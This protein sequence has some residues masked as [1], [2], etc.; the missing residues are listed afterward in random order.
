MTR[1]VAVLATAVALVAAG[2][3]AL[4]GAHDAA[5][6]VALAGAVACG[7]GLHVD[8]PWGGRLT[9]GH[10]LIIAILARAEPG[11]SLLIVAAG[12]VLSLPMWLDR[13]EGPRLTQLGGAAAAAVA[14]AAGVAA[15]LVLDAFLAESVR[16]DRRSLALAAGV[17]V[18]FLGV[19]HVLRGLVARTTGE[20]P[21]LRQAWPLYVTL[22]CVGALVD[23]A[24]QRSVALALVATLPLLVTRFSFQRYTSARRTYEQTTKALGLLPEVAGL[25]PLGHSE[26]T[27]AYVE[28]TATS[29]GFEPLRVA[30]LANA[31][32]LHHIGHISLHEEAERN[33]PPDPAQLSEVS[34]EILR[35]TGFLEDLVDLVQ[36]CQPAGPPAST[37][38]AA[39]IRLCSMLDELVEAG[40]PV[41]PF[42]ALVALHPVGH[43]RAAAI[44]LLALQHRRPSLVAE[45]R[46]AVA[47]ISQVAAGE[48]SH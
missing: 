20:R 27:A 37:L 17:G 38:D 10:A 48:R 7:V 23:L 18:A 44:A 8:L 21:D 46:A 33:A 11:S 24:V 25:T 36:D 45:A 6:A 19:D 42:A 29:L 26:R 9:V 2:A 34:G 31:A 15:R 47:L 35:E 13:E 30:R 16:G 28:A 41:D 22:L 32:R 43:E 39:I 4:V 5:A 1:K 40:E 14:A 3:L 12:L